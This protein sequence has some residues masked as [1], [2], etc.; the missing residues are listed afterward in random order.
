MIKKLFL[1][2]A[3]TFLTQSIHAQE[4]QYQYL[5]GKDKDHTVA[6]DFFI[7]TGMKS[8][9]WDKIQVP[10]NWEQQGFG[11]YN[12][13]KDTQN[14]E[15]TGQYKYKFK[16]AK[17]NAG[18]EIFI[19]FEAAMTEA[20]VKING[21]SA[22]PIHQG[23]F[24]T[25]QYN[26]TTL[27]NF[28]GENLLEVKVSKQ[29]ADK[30][31]NN[32]ERKADFWLFG[33]IF[34]PVYLKILPKAHV[35][36]IA[37]DAKANGT[38]NLDAYTA[39][40]PVGSVLKAQVQKLSGEK[41][42]LDISSRITDLDK[43]TTIKGQFKDINL[44]NPESPNLYQVIVSLSD[45]NG[46]LIHRIKQKFGFRT[47]ELRPQDGFYVN[48]KKVIFKGVNRHSEWPESGR[49]LSKALNIE[50]VKLI[51]EMNMNAV[52]MSHYPPDPSFLDACDSLGLFVI[53]E[54]TGWQA[55]YDTEV[56][57]KL[58][59]ELVVRDV[60]HPSIVMWANG[61]EGG[62]NFDLDHLYAKYDNQSRL[63]IHPWER[64]NGT[65][66]KHYPDY[67]YVV[68][69]TLYGTDVFFPTEFMHGLHDGGHGA[70][71]DDFWSM[72]MKHPYAAGGFL[73]SFADEG[74]TR[75][76]R[77]GEMDIQGNAAPDGI[78]GPHR[79][80]E[81]S[82]YTIKEIW[83]P[84]Q[85]T[86]KD[87]PVNF[88][89]KIAV[90][91]QYAFTNL[92]QCSF[93]WRLAKL[94]A[95]GTNNMAKV[96]ASG[97]LK[98]IG[99]LPG[100]KSFLTIPLPA[101]WTSNDVLYLTAFDPYK[102]EL[103]TWSW[104]VKMP[105]APV[106]TGTAAKSKIEFMETNK[107]LT[108]KVDGIIYLFDKKTG[109]IQSVTNSKSE[110][111]L[112]GGPAL[113]G[114]KCELKDFK[115]YTSG[116]DYIL[117]PVYNSEA[118][119]KVKWIFSSGKQV[120]LDYEYATQGEVDFMGIT[121]NYPE[122]NITGMAWEGNGPYRVWKNRLKGTSFGVWDTGFNNTITGESWKYPEFKGYYA[123]I[124]WVTI[125]NKQ[126]PF[127]VYTSKKNT[128]FQMLKPQK[129]AGATNNNTTPA[130]P[131]GDLG[132]LDAI[133]PIG[134]KFQSADKLGPQ[135][136]KNMQLNYSW[137]KGSLWFDFK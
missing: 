67:N 88:D 101:N 46:K 106:A 70:G 102:K 59:K 41:I 2:V 113:A 42:G 87:L 118:K 109:Y 84:V 94:P 28:E 25:F 80:K 27:L 56:G 112:S 115:H 7:N 134:T 55:K 93:E 116:E 73:W 71:L 117:E 128:F 120:K 33:G 61:N 60:N 3:I 21:K 40:A 75:L 132:F 19:V 114:V 105:V 53:N 108:L 64:F 69:T 35:D 65:D 92:N 10:S 16:V 9:H 54:L 133:S 135:S 78:L 45:A 50:D 121:F 90:E 123:N 34:R 39:N 31:V 79:E 103:F 77:N 37:I 51:K 76:D 85:I 104:P 96:S 20:E 111:S 44:W 127:T 48:N 14:P 82:F 119:F 12:Y 62:F 126:A 136:Q 100:E 91:N 32:A 137:N 5:S 95:A 130:F 38:F 26:I 15:E 122:A 30:S 125:K 97:Q 83:S 57:T 81:G 124:Y 98:G 6:W 11:T 24:Y 110:I 63:V 8:G 107:A 58:V 99:L 1:I 72:M 66:T 86:L 68:N 13:Y 18:K 47:A 131:D 23:G 74:V 49:T 43:A 129:A 17:S 52:R 4:T 22:G 89:G 36:R 29:S